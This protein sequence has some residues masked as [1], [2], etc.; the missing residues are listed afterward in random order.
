[1]QYTTLALGIFI[2]LFGFYT[3]IK[4]ISSPLELI[5][6]KYMK[7]KLGNKVGLII[8]TILYVIVPIIFASFMINAANNGVTIQR[9]ITGQ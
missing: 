5:R 4:S 2:L 3:A 7:A 1:M 6:L 9:F 8:H